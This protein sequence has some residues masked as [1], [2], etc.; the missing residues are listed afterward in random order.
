MP[1]A[2]PLYLTEDTL[3]PYNRLVID[4]SQHNAMEN[5]ALLNGRLS[6]KEAKE[7]AKNCLE[8]ANKTIKKCFKYEQQINQ[9]SY[10]EQW[11][12]EFSQG[13]FIKRWI[14]NKVSQNK[15]KA[16]GGKAALLQATLTRA[17]QYLMEMERYIIL[18]ETLGS[19]KQSTRLRKK[20][21]KLKGQMSAITPI[22]FPSSG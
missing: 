1:S 5:S 21:T 18:A 6:K 20:Q 2:P 8:Q 4:N 12:N 13:G 7:K 10:D 22:P 15:R 16:K 14:G 3:P 11:W 17:D 9:Y 19:R